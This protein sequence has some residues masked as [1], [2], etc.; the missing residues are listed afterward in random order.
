MCLEGGLVEFTADVCLRTQRATSLGAISGEDARNLPIKSRAL[1]IAEE[2]SVGVLGRSLQRDIGVPRPDALQIRLAPRCLRHR[3]SLRS[4][5]RLAGRGTLALDTAH[6]KR[7][8]RN[9]RGYTH[10]RE[11]SLFHL[12][13]GE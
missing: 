2:L 4:R 7:D 9:S 10:R 13:V 12:T 6:R 8:D 1:V 3:T 5:R 11:E